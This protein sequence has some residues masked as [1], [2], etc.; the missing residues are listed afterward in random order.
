ANSR[1]ICDSGFA[2]ARRWLQSLATSGQPRVAALSGSAAASG[3]S[4]WR[5]T[6]QVRRGQRATAR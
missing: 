1:L 5:L 4:Q 2:V 3:Q 6:A